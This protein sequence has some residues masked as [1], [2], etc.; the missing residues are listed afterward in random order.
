MANKFKRTFTNKANEEI[1]DDVKEK[2]EQIDRLKQLAVELSNALQDLDVQI[3]YVTKV[4]DVPSISDA[5]VVDELTAYQEKY[6]S[7]AKSMIL[8]F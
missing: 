2:T 4:V 8:H 6:Y 1:Y 3:S 7:Y 5:E